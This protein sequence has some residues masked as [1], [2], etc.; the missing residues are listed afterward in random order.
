M[1]LAATLALPVA[2]ATP[3]MVKEA[4]EIARIQCQE[5]YAQFLDVH[6]RLQ[7]CD[8]DNE[9]LYAQKLNFRKEVQKWADALIEALWYTGDLAKEAWRA[10]RK[11]FCV[12][13]DLHPLAWRDEVKRRLAY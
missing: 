5:A 13:L 7:G 3:D 9:D 11:I 2:Q 1:T 6:N 8:H 10:L 4:I 12:Y